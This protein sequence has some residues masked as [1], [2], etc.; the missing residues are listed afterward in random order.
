MPDF[1]A[2]FSFTISL[3]NRNPHASASI[4]TSSSS[5]DFLLLQT[6]SERIRAGL[7]RVFRCIAGVFEC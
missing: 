4:N 5:F 6:L 3:V 2:V 7:G 1:S